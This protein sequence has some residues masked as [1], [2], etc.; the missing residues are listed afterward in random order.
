MLS[1]DSWQTQYQLTLQ[2]Y[3]LAAETAYL[4][5]DFALTEQLAQI[6]L[7]KSKTLLDSITIHRVRLESCKA[8]GKLVAAL[9]IGVQVLQLL[10]VKFPANPDPEDIQAGMQQTQSLI[11]QYNIAELANLSEMTNPTQL[12]IMNI[13]VSLLP[14]AFNTLP[15]L[16]PLITFV[17]L[18]LSLEYGNTSFS[19]YGYA[20]YGWLLCAMVKEIE[21]GKQFGKVAAQVAEQLHARAIEPKV[22]FVI[23][24]FIKPWQCHLQETIEPL[25]ET[26]K[27]S[28]EMGDMEHAGWAAFVHSFHLYASG[29]ELNELQ[30]ILETNNQAIEQIQQ[31]TPGYHNKM[32]LQV[33]LNLLGESEAPCLLRGQIYDE[34][35]MTP[36]L[37]TSNSHKAL[38]YFHFHKLM[39]SYLFSDYAAAI[40]HAIKAKQYSA[41]IAGLYVVPLFNFYESLAYLAQYSQETESGQAEIIKIVTAA[42]ELLAEWAKSTPMNFQHK[43]WLVEAE[44]HRVLGNKLEA[45]ENY[46]RAI[47]G[48]K[49]HGYIQEEALANEL[50]AQFYFEWGKEKIAPIYLQ[51]AYFGYVCWGAKAKVK[52][53]EN[54]YSPYLAPK[55]DQKLSH[56]TERLNTDTVT[57]TYAESSVALDLAAVIKAS[58]HLSGEIQL[59]QLVTTLMQVVLENAGAEQ[60]VLILLQ[61]QQ[62]TLAAQC[63]KEQGCHLASMPAESSRSIPHTLINFVWRTSEIVVSSD[64]TAEN[65]FCGRSL[66]DRAA[67]EISIMLAHHPSRQAH[68]HPLSRK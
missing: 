27:C 52:D 49:K 68:G 10:G 1:P 60:G 64:A 56:P 59:E 12:A 19:A 57:S 58:Q 3:E 62:L 21:L 61:E 38:C 43:F 2:L 20:C 14:A 25:L 35:S 13:L 50:A 8:Q 18:K 36:L 31:E 7:Q 4:N 32:C 34:I 44:R 42:Q 67:A 39:L 5:R 22:N 48:A 9:D 15:L 24:Y 28:L 6:V 45:I 29:K 11:A 30:T 26:Y 37:L 53:L 16:F 41:A 17:M 65:L 46:D 63:T 23:Q 47:A 55:L 40:Q 33:V 66:Y 54:R 51:E